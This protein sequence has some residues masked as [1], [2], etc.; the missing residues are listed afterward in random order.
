M[1][2]IWIDI[3]NTPQVHFQ[4]SI[5]KELKVLNQYNFLF[6]AREFS[7]TTKLLKANLDLHFKIIGS[8]YGRGYFNKIL[9]LINRFKKM[10]KYIGEYDISISHGSEIAIW[11]SSL[12]GKRSIAF[13]DN[14]TARQ[15][16]YSLFVDFSFFPNAIPKNILTRQGLSSKK[17]YL[18]NGYKE[19]IYLSNFVPDKNFLN[20]LPFDNYVVVRPENLMANY[21]RNKKV[22]SI[23]PQLLKLLDAKGYNILYLPRYE[24]DKSYAKD[25]KNVFIPDKPVNGIDACYFSNAVLTGAG[26]FAREAA[27]L[28]IPAISFFSGKNILAVD[29]KMI[30]CGQMFF[31]RQPDE[32]IG[33][34]RN[35][36]KNEPDL[37]R[38]KVVQNEVIDKLKSVLESFD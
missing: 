21:I 17:L 24:L 10:H 30:K 27:C 19:D 18:Y 14:D 28:G 32:I 15:W 12:K 23:T 4:M 36:K 16:T 37:K 34:L 5:Y 31:S 33:Y 3:T 7:E 13:G 6:S 11:L 20:N 22:K 35:S 29:Q 9:G 38:S 26:T 8:H 25:I 2:T 1:K